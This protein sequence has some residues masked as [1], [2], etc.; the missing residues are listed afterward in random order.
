MALEPT[1]GDAESGY[2]GFETGDVTL[3][4]ID[5]DEQPTALDEQR[6]AGSG[7]DWACVGLRI[8]GVD[9]M[10]DPL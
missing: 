1:F 2:A 10:A 6:S 4:V 9:E 5:A 7:R 8:E 3:A